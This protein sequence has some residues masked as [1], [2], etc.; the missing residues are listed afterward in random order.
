MFTSRSQGGV[1][2]QTIMGEA[3]TDT[4]GHGAQ[5]KFAVGDLP[6]LVAVSWEASQERHKG[7]RPAPPPPPPPARKPASAARAKTAAP[8]PPAPRH[9]ASKGHQQAVPRKSEDALASAADRNGTPSYPLEH[10]E[11]CVS[12]TTVEVTAAVPA[13]QP[14]GDSSSA[15]AGAGNGSM[16]AAQASNPEPGAGLLCQA[17]HRRSAK[18]CTAVLIATLQ[19][20]LDRVRSWRGDWL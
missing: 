4:E 15:D 20:I 14:H 13:A 11:P 18:P 16:P 2:L 3:S 6:P 1:P 8:A 7:L 5:L 17:A 10:S 12:G 9:R 19:V